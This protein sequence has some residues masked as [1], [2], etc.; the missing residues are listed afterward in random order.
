MTDHAQLIYSVE[1]VQRL[2]SLGK[3]SI[4]KFIATGALKAIKI[5]RRTG[6]RAEDLNAFISSLHMRN[7][8]A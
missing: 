5:G 3:T 7:V 8:A 1:D 6:I 4:Y 2:T